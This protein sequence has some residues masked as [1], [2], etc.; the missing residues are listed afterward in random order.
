MAMPSPSAQELAGG[1]GI[2]IAALLISVLATYSYAYLVLG[3]LLAVTLLET[4]RLPRDA[5]SHVSR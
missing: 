3:A 4:L 5:G 1:L 2:A